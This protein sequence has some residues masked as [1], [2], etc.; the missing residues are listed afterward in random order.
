MTSLHRN[1]KREQAFFYK[2]IMLFERTVF[3]LPHSKQFLALSPIGWFTLLV[4]Y[5]PAF[6]FCILS[7]DHNKSA[8]I[9]HTIH[10]MK[11]VSDAF[12]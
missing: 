12:S 3:I 10:I 4:S 2:S 11:A 7:L 5:L 8:H 1:A 9:S 6:T